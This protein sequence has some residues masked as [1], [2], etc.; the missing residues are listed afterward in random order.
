[1]RCPPSNRVKSSSC[2]QVIVDEIELPNLLGEPTVPPR[3]SAIQDQGIFVGVA[4]DAVVRMDRRPPP[5]VIGLVA[6][7]RLVSRCPRCPR[8]PRSWSERKYRSP[9]HIFRCP[10]NRCGRHPKDQPVPDGIEATAALG[11]DDVR[12]VSWT[13]AACPSPPG[14]AQHPAPWCPSTRRTSQPASR[15]CPRLTHM[16]RC[17]RTAARVA[18][19]RRC[20]VEAKSRPVE[21]PAEESDRERGNNGSGEKQRREKDAFH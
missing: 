16:P 11:V 10:H 6:R 17:S 5:V 7:H 9:G 12:H 21:R 8:G 20:T 2:V 18:C 19:R 13:L 14:M 15:Q 1:M 3:R 4:N